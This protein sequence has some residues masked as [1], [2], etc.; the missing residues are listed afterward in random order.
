[1]AQLANTPSHLFEKDRNMIGYALVGSNDLTAAKAFYDDLLGS[2]GAKSVMEHRS[3]GR[4][5]AV[6][7]G[8]PM[9]GV[10]APAD[11]GAATVGNGT[12]ISFSADSRQQVDDFHAK[13]LELGATDEGP[14]G[15]RGNDPDGFYGAYFR[16]PDGN[17]LCVYRYGP[18]KSL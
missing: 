10:V 7:P 5:Y 4:I 17:K 14:P 3:G 9:F 18:A 11:G 6:T 8:N 1:M 2:I 16:D 13:A 12:M 15:V